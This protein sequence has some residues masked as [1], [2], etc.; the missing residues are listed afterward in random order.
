M[1][2]IMKN[3]VLRL[4]K[5]LLAVI[6][7]VLVWHFAAGQANKN[8]LLPIPLPLDTIGAFFEAA[9]EAVFWKSVFASIWHIIAGFGVAV[10]LGLFCGL[11]CIFAFFYILPYGFSNRLEP[12]G[13]RS[14]GG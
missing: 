13:K 9:G 14:F 6:F 7:W 8:L 3:K 4:L 10:V 5:S 11:L 2:S 1:I 12:G